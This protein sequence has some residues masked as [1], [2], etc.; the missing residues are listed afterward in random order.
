[1]MMILTEANSQL[2]YQS[3]LAATSTV[4]R[5]CHHTSLAVPS[6]GWFPVS[7]D[8]SGSPQYFPVVLSA[9]IS[10]AV[11]ST[12]WFPVSRD[13]WQPPVLPA[14]PGHLWSEWAKEMRIESIC[15]CGTS[16]DLLHAAKSYDMGPPALFPSEGRCAAGFYR[17]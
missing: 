13:L 9:E 11:Q 5:S 3:P 10:V 16:G 17:P 14:G 2:V 15:P 6:T 12:G 8:I 7:T 4:W 1:M